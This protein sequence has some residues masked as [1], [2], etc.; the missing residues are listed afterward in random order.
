MNDYPG[1]DE[2]LEAVAV[3]ESVTKAHFAKKRAAM[4]EAATAST[5]PSRHLYAVPNPPNGKPRAS[6]R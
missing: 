5:P 3:L 4:R 6:R 1:V 2:L